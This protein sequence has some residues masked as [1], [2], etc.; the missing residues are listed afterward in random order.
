MT[1]SHRQNA[2]DGKGDCKAQLRDFKAW[3]ECNGRRCEERKVFEHLN[4]QGYNIQI[5]NNWYKKSENSA[6]YA[7]KVELEARKNDDSRA[8]DRQHA[9]SL[10]QRETMAK[11]QQAG[12]TR[13]EAV[14][15]K[16][17]CLFTSERNLQHS[18]HHHHAVAYCK[19]AKYN[20]NAPEH[21][22]GFPSARV[23]SG[24]STAITP[25]LFGVYLL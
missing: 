24:G 17:T 22:H 7:G 5:E 2:Q 20:L 25:S 16:S 1:A 4:R 18:A 8:V 3:A 19:Q 12:Q 6:P 15:Q 9:D 10:V 11:R 23:F 13:D 21:V 14:F